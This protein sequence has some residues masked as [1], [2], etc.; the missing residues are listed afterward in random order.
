[1]TFNPFCKHI[2]SSV[3]FAFLVGRAEAQPVIKQGPVVDSITSTSAR[4]TWITNVSATTVIRFGLTRTYDAVTSGPSNVTTHSWY[5]SGLAPSTTYHFQVCSTSGT[6]ACS[7]DKTLTTASSS[8][9]GPRD[10]EPPRAKVDTTMPSGAYGPAFTIDA[11]CTNLAAVV[12]SLASLSGNLNYEIQI[13]SGTTCKG[14]FVFPRR[15]NHSGWIVVRTASTLPPEGTRVTADWTSQLATLQTDALPATRMSL[16]YLPDNCYPGTLYW[17]FAVPGMALLECKSPGDSSTKRITAG[18]YSGAGPV[19]ITVPGHGY[20]TGNVIRISGTGLGVD[21]KNWMITVINSNTFS[22]NGSHGAGKFSGG[23]AIRNGKWTQVS[24][25]SGTQLPGSCATNSW[26]FKTDVSP[27]TDAV[28]WCTSP[29]KWTHARAINTSDGKNY[30]AIQ[31][32][33]H[34]ARYRFIGLEV[35]QNPAPN[36]PPPTWSQKNFKQGMIGSLVGMKPTNSHIIF[37]RCDIHGLDYPARVGHGMDLDGSHVAVIHS[38][39]HKINHWVEGADAGYLEAEAIYIPNGPGPGKIEN[40]LIEAI[41]ITVFFPDN[42]FHHTP[43]ADYEIRRNFFAHPDKYL[44]GSPLNTSGKNYVNRHHIEL[45]RGQRMLIEGNT[46]DN[47]WADNNQ[48]AFIMLTP[49]PGRV[50]EA[51]TITQVQHGNVTV[52][53]A[54]DPYTPGMLVSITGSGAGNHDGIWEVA[55]VTGPNTFTLKNPP[56]GYG[57]S[58]KVVAVASSVQISDIDFK[59]NIFRYGPNVLW[60]TGHHDGSGTH[61]NTKTTERIRFVNNLVYGMDA[62]SLSQGGRVSPLGQSKNGRSGVVVF[63]ALGMEDLILRNNTVYDFKGNAPSFLVPDSLTAGAHAGLD[64]RDNIFTARPPQPVQIRG[65]YFGADALNRQWTAHPNP[66]WTFTNNLFCCNVSDSSK[67][68]NPE[69]NLWA[70]TEVEIGFQSP[71][72]NDF[73]L[74]LSSPFKT[75]K[76]CFSVVGDC[77]SNGGDLGVDMTALEAATQ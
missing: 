23:T 22:L 28:Y 59:S 3:L 56:S 60:I 13:P 36:P 30:A 44:Y 69:G 63:A 4:I 74:L 19:T 41:G 8:T 76:K 66:K 72:T 53:S 20:H 61:L 48:G 5:L 40:N 17:G 42:S 24:H 64:V 52:S 58:G 15:P 65:T 26:F 55:N 43:P 11:N 51:K 45:K 38:R 50:P 73:R 33:D 77:S 27:N 49:R 32:E 1:M 62:R 25:K 2:V 21:N 71:T 70:E 75:G 16:A 57:T 31:F 68:R 37:D 29:G 18:S 12:N 14:Q 7:A 9:G 6:E 67:A 35:T 47:N 39:I 54:S 10:P 34:A 46:F